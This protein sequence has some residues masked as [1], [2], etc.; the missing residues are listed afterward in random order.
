MTSKGIHTGAALELVRV[1]KTFGPVIAVDGVSLTVAPGEFLTLLGP[2]GSGKTTTLMMIAGFESATA[3]EIVLDGRPLTRVPPYR[4]NLGMVFQHYALFPH[5]TV[6]D[7][8]AFPL[9]TRGATRTETDKRVEEALDRVHLP[10]YGGRFPV[11]LSGG[12]QQRVALARALVYRPPV[13]LMDEPLGALDKKLREQMQLEIKHIQRELQLTVIYVTHDQEEALTMSDRIVV[14]RHGRVVQLGPPE[15]LYERPT[16][17][18]VADFI[19]QSNFLEVTVR[20]VQDGIATAVTDDGLDVSLVGEAGAEG[21]RV[22]LAL[23]PERVRL[24]P[25]GASSRAA[26]APDP[27]A[28]R[29]WD[30]VIEEVVYIGATRK[31]QVRLRGQVLVAQQQAG[32]DVTGL[33]AGERVNVGWSMAD[34]RVVHKH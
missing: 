19:G 22:T 15:D 6:H 18:F 31:Y 5:M 2:S 33:R 11:Q 14:M 3:G 34:L 16:D 20:S 26:A 10:G 24:A 25:A 8:V 17:R 23:R 12:Q 13:L 30:G 28:Y 4:R 21:T 9:R 7:N 32:T 29:W 1:S 27:S